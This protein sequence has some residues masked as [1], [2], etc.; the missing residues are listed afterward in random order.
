M[1]EAAE[2]SQPALGRNT[3]ISLDDSE[4]PS[5]SRCTLHRPEF[6]DAPGWRPEKPKRRHETAV[7][8]SASHWP[9]PF[10]CSAHCSA[11]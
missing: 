4:Q 9:Q 10:R 5:L 11:Q 8:I 7:A 2:T 3:G 1:A 6:L